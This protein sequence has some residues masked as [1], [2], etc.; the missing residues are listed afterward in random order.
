MISILIPI[1][2]TSIVKLVQ[3][4]VDQCVGTKRAFEIIC[5]DDQSNHKY[6]LEN[7]EINALL[8]VNYVELSEKYGRA[9]IRNK[10]ASLARFD[11]LLFID[12]DSK[13]SSKKYIKRY[14]EAILSNRD[15]VYYGGRR[16]S[17]KRPKATS[18]LLHWLYG[19]HR[20]SP[21][22]KLRNRRPIEFLHTNNVLVPKRYFD[23]EQFDISIEGYGYEDIEWAQRLNSI[24]SIRHINNPITHGTLKKTE[25]FLSDIR[26]SLQNLKRLHSD[27]KIQTSKLIRTY[28]KLEK[29]GLLGATIMLLKRTESQI[30][31]R[32]TSEK[33]K[34]IYLDLYKLHYFAELMMRDR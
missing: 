15:L 21:A 31:E 4:L 2:N 20:E 33:T 32:L 1:Y 10:L 24:T 7:R 23:Q 6:L 26:S 14:I 30:Y 12:S 34:L 27:Q 16:Y 5:L 17:N 9:K 11:H 19:T 3:S 25:Q 13:I 28:N 22:A 8:G 18:K 29:Y